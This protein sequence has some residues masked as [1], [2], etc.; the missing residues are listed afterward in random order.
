MALNTN[1]VALP[2]TPLS[3]HEFESGV[4]TTHWVPEARYAWDAGVAI[5]RYLEGL[6]AGEIICWNIRRS[7][8]SLRSTGRTRCTASSTCWA[9]A[10]RLRQPA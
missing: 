10:T 7:R 3:R 5:G 4:L 1:P 8:L 2:G 9:S 6:Q